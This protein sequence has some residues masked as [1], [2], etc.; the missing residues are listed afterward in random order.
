MSDFRN[1]ASHQ[2]R[3][4]SDSHGIAQMMWADNKKNGEKEEIMPRPPVLEDNQHFLFIETV[5]I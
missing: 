1:R 4:R 5:R 2:M 3:Q